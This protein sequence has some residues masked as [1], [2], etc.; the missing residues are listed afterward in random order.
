M[1]T[2]DDIAWLGG[3]EGYGVGGVER[4]DGEHPEI[5][6]DLTPAPMKEM[7]C[8]GCGGRGLHEIVHRQVRDLPILD[9]AKWLIGSGQASDAASRHPSASTPARFRS[10][11]SR[12]ANPATRSSSNGEPLS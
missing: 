7:I 4:E 6:I 9:S 12:P 11:C 5:W 8:T 2:H 10:A 1:S 3:W